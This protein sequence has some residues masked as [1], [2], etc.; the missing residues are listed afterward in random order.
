M[1][2]SGLQRRSAVGR[3]FA[4]LLGSFLGVAGFTLH[5]AKAT[6]YLSDDPEVCVNCHIMRRNYDGWQQSS[7]H[8]VATCVDCHLP[9]DFAGKY[10]AKALNGYY[11]SKAFTL[12]GF[13]EPIRI[14]PRNA[15]ILQESCLRCHEDMVHRLVAGPTTDRDAVR[16][17]HCHQSAGHGEPMGLGGPETEAEREGEVR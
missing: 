7:H 6:S 16:C 8:S 13:P 17:V 14:T 1:E 3:I 11:H 5:Y 10:A 4:V 9:G 12:G 15:S 2:T